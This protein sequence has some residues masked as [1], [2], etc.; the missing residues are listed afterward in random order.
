MSKDETRRGNSALPTGQPVRGPQASTYTN[1]KSNAAFESIGAPSDGGVVTSP[2]PDEYDSLTAGFPS[3]DSRNAVKG[4]GS[5]PD[6]DAINRGYVPN[7]IPMP[8][9]TNTGARRQRFGIAPGNGS[10]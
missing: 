2:G 7:N 10:Q 4:G 1:P 9:T 3:V 5:L 8:A 6:D